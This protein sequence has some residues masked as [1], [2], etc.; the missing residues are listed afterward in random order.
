MIVSKNVVRL[1]CQN[2]YDYH[3][4]AILQMPV[5]HKANEEQKK[6]IKMHEAAANVYEKAWQ[7]V[8]NQ[9]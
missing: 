6:K 5:Y 7:K 8:Q 4:R 9:T 3:V 1:A 2:F